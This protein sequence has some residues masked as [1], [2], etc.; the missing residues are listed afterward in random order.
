MNFQ[1]LTITGPIIGYIPI[2]SVQSLTF[3]QKQKVSRFI[4]NPMYCHVNFVKVEEMYNSVQ[5]HKLSFSKPVYQRDCFGYYDPI[6]G[7]GDDIGNEGEEI[8]YEEED[9]SSN[10]CKYLEIPSSP[11]TSILVHTN[12]LPAFE[13]VE[14]TI[15]QTEYMDSDNYYYYGSLDTCQYSG[16]TGY[17]FFRKHEGKK[18]ANFYFNHEYYRLVDI[19]NSINLL[20]KMNTDLQCA[21]CGADDVSEIDLLNS[22]PSKPNEI[23]RSSSGNC[24]VDVMALYTLLAQENGEPD[25]A[26]RLGVDIMNKIVE[27]S[28]LDLGYRYVGSKMIDL[29]EDMYDVEDNTDGLTWQKAIST[30]EESSE[31]EDFRTTTGGDLTLLYTMGKNISRDGSTFLGPETGKNGVG[32]FALVRIDA[33]FPFIV[34]HELGHLHGCQHYNGQLHEKI[35]IGLGIGNNGAVVF[36][37]EY[38]SY[39]LDWAFDSE[40]EFPT[41]MGAFIVG[42][43]PHLPFFSNR[44]VRYRGKKVGRKDRNN[45]TAL[46][47]QHCLLSE[48]SEAAPRVMKVDITGP[49][50]IANG[51]TNT[52]SV[53]FDHCE[54]LVSILWEYSS[55]GV[56][57]TPYLTTGSTPSSMTLETPQNNS[58]LFIRVTVTCESDDGFTSIATSFFMAEHTDNPF[59]CK[60]ENPFQENDSETTHRSVFQ[61]LNK[62]DVN[63]IGNPVT[64][65]LELVFVNG[66]SSIPYS[67]SIT[68]ELGEKVFTTQ[69]VRFIENRAIISV[70]PLKKGLYFVTI[71]NSDS[72]STKSF[73]KL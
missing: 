63:I 52:W 13:N 39:A 24:L 31:F 66:D 44:K 23:N 17:V 30:T 73:V 35:D 21:P 3:E 16:N 8:D 14:Y 36:K 55:D 10:N 65:K 18:F 45:V 51:E 60:E 5:N 28:D 34:T 54:N 64:D 56:T 41:V 72:Q 6:V 19:G 12:Y 27:N 25:Q 59:G 48:Y 42:Q 57:Y 11:D 4:L 1:K 2:D 15:Y 33:T 49:F 53:N 38:R 29:D 68:S 9:G 26:A 62:F 69:K 47:D 70:A 67:I 43:S 58:N 40:P 46:Q 50:I 32:S 37:E 71:K 61:E 22:T 20:L 7:T